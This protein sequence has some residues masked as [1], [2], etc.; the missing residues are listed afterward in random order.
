[1]WANRS[2]DAESAVKFVAKSEAHKPAEV[3]HALNLNILALAQIRLERLDA[4]RQTLKAA[5]EAIERL[6]ADPGKRDHDLLIAQVLYRETEVLIN[7][8]KKP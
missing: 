2:G 6:Q 8:Q 7:G 1:L 3:A 5:Q 4:A